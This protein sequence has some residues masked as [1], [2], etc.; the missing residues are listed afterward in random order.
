MLF[1]VE[2]RR[3][4]SQRHVLYEST[5]KYINDPKTEVKYDNYRKLVHCLSLIFSHCPNV[6]IQS[7]SEQARYFIAW[8][9]DSGFLQNSPEMLVSYIDLIAS[10]ANGEDGSDRIFTQMIESAR[11]Q[12]SV[13][14]EGFKYIC[15]DFIFESLV[16][17]CRVLTGT[18]VRTNAVVRSEEMEGFGAYL[19]L[20]GK[21]FSNASLEQTQQ[22]I[23]LL[24]NEFKS[25][26]ESQKLKDLFLV[27]FCK[28]VPHKLKAAACEAICGIS[29]SPELALS[30]LRN[31]KYVGLFALE[32]EAIRVPRMY[33]AV[34]LSSVEAQ[35]MDYS[36]T[37]SCIKMSNQLL[38]SVGKLEDRGSSLIEVTMFCKD[39]LLEAIWNH[40]SFNRQEQLWELLSAAFEHFVICL[41]R[42]EY[43]DFTF[44]ENSLSPSQLVLHNVLGQGVI[45]KSI[46][47]CVSKAFVDRS[48]NRFQ[49][50]AANKAVTNAID[51]MLEVFQKENQLQY[52]PIEGFQPF[53]NSIL[54]NKELV[55]RSLYNVSSGLPKE[56][57]YG[58]VELMRELYG[59]SPEK[60]D[61][62]DI[63]F[64]ALLMQELPKLF[65]DN[66]SVMY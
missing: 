26:L 44:T 40:L 60:F 8:L 52:S 28:S 19:R 12:F 2:S 41:E 38:Q 48:S 43:E 29:R 27:I 3:L 35:M 13:T 39:V 55:Q 65:N 21:I 54:A 1:E 25:S 4:I 45:Y 24:E 36:F 23:E 17:F 64:Q 62:L 5:K 9:P 11:N 58:A 34:Q 66:T 56:L 14:C 33:L 42:M 10:L 7:D 37:I 18:G 31:L 30:I 49:A 63:E 46:C 53:R 61:A 59:K 51:L 47:S 20:L 16:S 32:S 57:Q 50:N 22:R 6:I 15:W